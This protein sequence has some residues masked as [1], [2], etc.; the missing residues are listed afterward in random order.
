MPTPKS[1]NQGRQARYPNAPAAF[2]VPSLK[3]SSGYPRGM[4]WPLL[5]GRPRPPCAGRSTDRKRSARSRSRAVICWDVKSSEGPIFHLRGLGGPSAAEVC[6]ACAGKQPQGWCG[7]DCVLPPHEAKPPP[8]SS[9]PSIPSFPL[10]PP[11][12]VP[13]P[14]AVAGRL[15]SRHGEALRPQRRRAIGGLQRHGRRPC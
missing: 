7:L 4:A 9:L 8:L 15:L 2:G 14:A 6:V 3:L 10:S 13:S 11:F 12:L 1:P 5:K